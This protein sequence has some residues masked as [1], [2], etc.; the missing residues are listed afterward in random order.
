M[1][2]NYTRITAF[3]FF[4]S[5]LTW[6][7]IWVASTGTVDTA[8]TAKVLF[9]GQLAYVQPSLTTGNVVLR[10]NVLPVGDLTVPLTQACCE[11]RGLMVRFLDNGSGAQVIV[12]LKRYNVKTGQVT[13]LLTFDSNAFPPK[14]AFQDSVPL[15]EG[16]FFNFSFATGPTEGGQDLGGDSA[17]YIEAQLIRSAA[18][19]T[20][21][22][23]AIR[24]VH[25]LSP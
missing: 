23:G 6:G 5:S 25:Q 21:G 14:S 20:P 3:A 12:K 24:I 2:S 11:S 8:S 22:L 15:G 16:S 4:L 18:G 13:T 7:Q 10:Y 9:A 1:M 19:G 17:Y